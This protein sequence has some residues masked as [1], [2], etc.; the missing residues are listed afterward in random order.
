MAVSQ[1]QI[2]L[3]IQQHLAQVAQPAPIPAAAAPTPYLPVTAPTPSVAPEPHLSPPERYDGHPGGCRAFLTMCSLT[4]ELQP[5]TYASERSRVAFII[6]HLTGRAREWAAAEWKRQS[7]CVFTVS[8]FSQE[9][10]KVFDQSSSGREA[11]RGLLHLCQGHRS[12]QDY[13]IDFWTRAANSQWNTHSLY[14]A[15]YHGLSDLI[16]DELA[17]RELPAD[18]DSL[19]LLT[20]RI[21]NRL[22]ERKRNRS[23][24][25]TA[26]LD[27][28]AAAGGILRSSSPRT[29]SDEP[30]QVGRTRLSEEHQRRLQLNLCLYCGH[31]GHRVC[32]CPLGETHQ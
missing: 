28:E 1:G 10:R 5:R 32:S 22:M 20:I 18:L 12:I 14:D 26:V 9:L 31:P 23:V 11:A 19:I 24:T 7:L 3:S 4:F 8:L 25:Q 2:L 29:D 17:S 15:Y 16:K 6:S 30:M 27:P 21:D 13:S